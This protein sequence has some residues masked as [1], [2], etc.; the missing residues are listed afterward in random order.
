MA[1]LTAQSGQMLM[2]PEQPMPLSVVPS[3]LAHSHNNAYG[4]VPY[5]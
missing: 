4:T 3:V 5:L 1:S 2:A